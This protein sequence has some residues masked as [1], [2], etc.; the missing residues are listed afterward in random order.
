[1]KVATV[2]QAARALVEHPDAVIVAGGTGLQ[3]EWMN[4]L[5]RPSVLVDVSRIEDAAFREIGAMT[6][7]AGTCLADIESDVRVPELLRRAAASVAASQVRG[8]AT[9]GGNVA[10]RTGCLIP[11]LLCFEAQAEWHDGDHLR[12]EPRSDWLSQPAGKRLLVRKRSI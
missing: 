9:L 12:V 1:M 10:G 6:I 8:L 5:R 4:G 2:L 7:G 3:I 11:A